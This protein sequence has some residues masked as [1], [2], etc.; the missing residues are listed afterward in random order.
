[1]EVSC[2][3]MTGLTTSRT[4]YDGGTS[5]L[6]W[7][8]EGVMPS[9]RARLSFRETV[10]ASIQV[11]ATPWYSQDSRMRD[12]DYLDESEW[13]RQAH[14]GVDIY[15]ETETEAKTVELSTHL[16]FLPVCTG[17]MR[18]GLTAG[19]SRREHDFRGFDTI[20]TGH[21]PWVDQARTLK[22]PSTLYSVKYEIYSAGVAVE[23]TCFESLAVALEWASLPVVHATDEDDHLRR[24]RAGR[25]S[26]RGSGYRTSVYALAPVGR[27][28]AVTMSCTHE[29]FDT[30]GRQTQYW[31]GDDPATPGFNDT[32]YG[33]GG[34]R[35]DLDSRCT[36]LSIGSRVAF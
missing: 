29:R 9:M 26:T 34:I 31:Y 12:F 21:G 18:A 32:G 3:S 19:Y 33:L 14:E 27:R 11:T 4:S 22:G 7:P 30:D 36:T 2:V 16:R 13:N 10:D 6:K 15:S 17:F 24:N 28:L 25:S 8:V 20:Q 23:W 35:T 1:M 5:V